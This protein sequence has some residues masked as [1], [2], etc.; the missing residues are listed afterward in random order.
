MSGNTN[1]KGK[2][3]QN[4]KLVIC[5]YDYDWISHDFYPLCRG[6]NEK[7]L[8]QNL[9]KAYP[10]CSNSSTNASTSITTTPTEQPS[11]ITTT[12]PTSEPHI[13]GKCGVGYGKCPS[14]QCCSKYGWC[15]KTDDYCSSSKGCQ[16]EFGDC[17]GTSSIPITTSVDGKCG[18][19]YGTCPSGQCC[20]KYGWCGKTDAYCSEGCQSKFGDCRGTITTVT[21]TTIT[22]SEPSVIEKCGQGIDSCSSGYCCSKNGLCG[23]SYEHCSVSEGCQSA[24]GFCKEDNTSIEGKCGKNYGKC[25]SDQCCSKYGWCGKT[26]DYCSESKGCQSE[27]GKCS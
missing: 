25:P 13:Q 4:E 17:N 20:S 16:S 8:A 12:T 19:D 11:S 15:G 9:V 3:L 26:P 24:Y 2:V 6:G 27:F 22:I 7:C 23:K 1:L 10:L 5:E 21:E 18:E 14:G